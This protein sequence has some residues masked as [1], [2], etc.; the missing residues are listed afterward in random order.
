MNIPSIGTEKI[1]QHC[2][3]ELIKKQQRH[4]DKSYL[5]EAKLTK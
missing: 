2:L 4:E 3:K 5:C 1:F